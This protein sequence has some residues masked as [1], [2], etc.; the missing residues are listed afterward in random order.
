MLLLSSFIFKGKEN[1]NPL[2]IS[3]SFLQCVGVGWK[4]TGK[5]KSANRQ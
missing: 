5:A 3:L 2:G 4:E 1:Q